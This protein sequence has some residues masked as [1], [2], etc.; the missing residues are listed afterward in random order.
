MQWFHQVLEGRLLRACCNLGLIWR[1]QLF[2]DRSIKNGWLEEKMRVTIRAGTLCGEWR[3]VE[4]PDCASVFGVLSVS[5]DS[6]SCYNARVN[7]P[8]SKSDSK[9]RLHFLNAHDSCHRVPTPPSVLVLRIR[10]RS[11]IWFSLPTEEAI[12]RQGV[13]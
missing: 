11:V 1:L 6:I 3:A 13:V 9:Y 5:G 12:P 7:T 2:R 10:P 4:T 8:E